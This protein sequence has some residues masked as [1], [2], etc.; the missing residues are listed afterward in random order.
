[1]KD[2]PLF[3]DTKFGDG[4][5]SIYALNHNLLVI[6]ALVLGF[7]KIMCYIYVPQQTS[8]YEMK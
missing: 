4:F 2:L 8:S 7:L 3:L 5:W 6:A 1:M